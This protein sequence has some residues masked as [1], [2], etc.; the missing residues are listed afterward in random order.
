VHLELADQGE[1][2]DLSKKTR[3]GDWVIGR[4]EFRA[5]ARGGLGK[6]DGRE[7]DEEWVD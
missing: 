5:W 1:E 4:S 3:L 7:V 2:L 6:L